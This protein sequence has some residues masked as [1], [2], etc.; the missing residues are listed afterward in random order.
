VRSQHERILVKIMMLIFF[1][2]I[3]FLAARC[4]TAAPPVKAKFYDFSEHLI[5][6]HIKRPMALY[7][8]VRQA[9]KFKRLLRIKK[10]FM[11]ELFKSARDPVFK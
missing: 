7:T 1:F 11:K 4:A 10:S 2:I 8:D 6:G 5:D 3:G 9:A